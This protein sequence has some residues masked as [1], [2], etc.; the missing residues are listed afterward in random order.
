MATYQL[1]PKLQLPCQRNKKLE[2]NQSTDVPMLL[3]RLTHYM[4]PASSQ[5]PFLIFILMSNLKYNNI[6]KDFGNTETQSF[7]T[8]LVRLITGTC[9]H[10][11]AVEF[12][13]VITNEKSIPCFNAIS[14]KRYNKLHSQ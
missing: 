9:G 13:S 14:F 7:V 1:L 5:V 2:F 10:P 4:L 12:I 8:H 6:I 3:S 11:K